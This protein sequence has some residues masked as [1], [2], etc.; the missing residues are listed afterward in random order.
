M[1]KPVLAVDFDDVVAGFNR[2]F[3][4]WH[5]EHYGTTITYDGIYTYDMA[6]LYGTDNPTIHKRVMEFCHHYHDT[7]EPIEGAI[8]NLRLLKRRYH[9][10]IVTSRCE[11]IALITNSWKM[12]HAKK[13]FQAAHFTNGFAS[14]FPERK[15]SKLTVCEEIN[16]VALI[17]DAVGHANE[18]AAGA[19][20]AVFLPN[21]PWNQE[22]IWDGVIRVDSWEE[23]TRQLMS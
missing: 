19:G 1:A 2:A 17:D 11:S 12:R 7:I 4:L 23:I 8:E 20:I 9:L 13:I 15:R 18:V 6:V 14:K 10:E 16:A 22:E 5:N 21:R 3:V